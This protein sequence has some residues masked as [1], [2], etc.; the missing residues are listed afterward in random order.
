MQIETSNIE[1]MEEK[2]SQLP[3]WVVVLMR[4]YREYINTLGMKNGK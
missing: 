1:D 4:D 2:E 3:E